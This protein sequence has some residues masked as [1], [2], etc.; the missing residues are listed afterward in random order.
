MAEIRRQLRSRS[1]LFALMLTVVLLI[2]NVIALP[3]FGAPHNWT[4]N[5]RLFAPFMLIAMASTPAIVSGGGGL[6]LSVGPTAT[7]VNVILVSKLLT[8]SALHSPVLAIPI[9]LAIG[10]A[11]GLVN[12]FVVAV[13]RF[14]PVIATLCMF[15]VLGGVALEIAPT[16]VGA[17]PSN[18]TNDLGGTLLGI[19]GPLL[20][21][22]GAVV[23]WAVLGRTPMLRHLYG[24]GANDAAAFAAGVDVTAI[25]FFAYALDGVF[26]ALAGIALTV[27]I[28]S[29]D[30]TLATSYTLIAV[31]AVVLGGT[32]IGGGRGGVLGS[33]LG[34]ATIFLLQ[35][36]L[37]SVHV[38][39]T[40]DQVAYGAML[41]AGV[42]VGAVVTAPRAPGASPRGS[43][44]AA[45]S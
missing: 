15:F 27:V 25:R 24:V 38:S 5:L 21:M 13:L 22:L 4:S 16:A 32:P 19:P 29:G 6:D 45:S 7:V 43:R 2:A 3:A 36:F 41:L 8:S 34:A 35:N 17:P 37:N 44:A 42:L 9:V 30:P 14:P 11:I 26:A 23:I 10:A 12:G 28:Q 31:A 20:L 18:W 33:I 39:A 1:Y 40:W